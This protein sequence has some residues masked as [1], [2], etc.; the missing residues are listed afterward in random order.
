MDLKALLIATLSILVLYGCM[1][2][3]NKDKIMGKWESKPRNN[4]EDI[5]VPVSEL[6]KRKLIITF[7]RDF[8]M[9]L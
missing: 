1:P 4:S 6:S 7:N 3:S 2:S 9:N 8:S 5:Q